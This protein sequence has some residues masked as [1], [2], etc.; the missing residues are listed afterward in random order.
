MQYLSSCIWLVSLSIMSP[1]FIHVVSNGKV[2]AFLK[3]NNIP[4]S[5]CIFSTHS[6]VEGP[7]GWLHSLPIVNNAAVNL[8]VQV[9]CSVV[10]TCTP[11][12]STA[13]SHGCAIFNFW[14]TP[15][16]FYNGCISVYS[17]QRCTRIPFSSISLPT[18]GIVF[19]SFWWRPC[20]GCDMISH[21]RFDLHFSDDA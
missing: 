6:S 4:L 1:R 5:V 18:L 20:R 10:Y 8:A 7:L 14:R 11:R 16:C 9:S 3:L 21:C 12:G 17:S 13:G 15:N 2:P 19:L